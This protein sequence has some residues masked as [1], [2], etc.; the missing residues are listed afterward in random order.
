LGHELGLKASHYWR[1]YINGDTVNTDSVVVYYFSLL[2][3]FISVQNTSGYENLKSRGL[4]LIQDDS[5][6]N[7]IIALYEYDYNTLKTFEEEY[8]ETQ[9]HSNYFKELNQYIAPQ[10]VFDAKGRIVGL[11]QPLV[12]DESERKVAL[13]YLWKIEGNRQFTLSLY[14]QIKANIQ[15]LKKRLEGSFET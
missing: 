9:F 4:E 6:R 13:S 1:N 14:G 8:N 10:L 2:R 11:D 12:M 15:A 3:D 5:L 7:A